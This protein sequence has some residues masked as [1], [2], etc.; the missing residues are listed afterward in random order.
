MKKE[1]LRI[2]VLPSQ[3][4]NNNTKSYNYL[5]NNNNQDFNDELKQNINFIPNNNKNYNNNFI[6]NNHFNPFLNSKNNIPKKE[7]PQIINKNEPINPFFKKFSNEDKITILE[8]ENSRLK[9]KIVD[10][11]KKI[12]QLNKK[13]DLYENILNSNNL[14]T[15]VIN[16]NKQ[17]I[18]K[19]ENSI[20]QSLNKNQPF[21]NMGIPNNNIFNNT[22]NFYLQNYNNP[23][24]IIQPINNIDDPLNKNIFKNK[25]N[26]M[27]NINNN[28]FNNLNFE[29]FFD[30]KTLPNQK[31][32]HKYNIDSSFENDNNISCSFENY[33]DE[34]N[35]DVDNMTYEEL[36]ELENKIGYVKTGVSIEQ[37]LSL[38]IEQYSPN[39]IDC[40]EC[41]ICKELFKENEFIRLLNCSHVFH[42]NCIDEW[43]KDNKICPICKKEVE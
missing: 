29:N 21:L 19:N 41:V 15:N 2:N 23:F 36:L 33:N 43:F 18:Q 38:K 7:N 34:D 31:N 8:N 9:R 39:K 25:I 30:N 42:I 1:T 4:N 5:N 13:I 11:N 3:N 14:S 24:K 26:L 28:N 6:N 27:N 20:L 12:I 32:E 35:I 37:K 22:N 40:K 10:L 16:N 17:L